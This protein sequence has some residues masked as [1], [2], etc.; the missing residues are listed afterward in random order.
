MRDFHRQGDGGERRYRTDLSGGPRDKR[1]EVTSDGTD[2]DWL[3]GLQFARNSLPNF[4]T[5]FGIPRPIL[6]EDG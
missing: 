3:A 1:F 4:A 2:E 6:E 5:Q